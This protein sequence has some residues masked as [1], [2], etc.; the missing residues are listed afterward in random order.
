MVSD[1]GSEDVREFFDRQQ[2]D[3]QYESL[4]NMT[5]ELDV[6]AARL[7]NS[8]V[9][10]DT[11]SIGGIW[12]FFTWEDQMTSLTVLDL[13]P[14]MLKSYCPEHA[15]G[16][17]GDI[18]EQEFPPDSF[19]SIV[20]PLMLHHT[21]K[22][23]WASCEARVEEAIDRARGWLREDGHLFIL[24]YCPQRAWSP[25]QRALLPL[26]KWFLTTF[27][28]PLVVMYEKRFYQ[29]ILNERFGS[30]TIQLVDPPGFN[31]R[32]WYPVFM[33]IRWLRVPMAI[34][35]KLHVISAPALP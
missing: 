25:I 10:G 18:Y 7:L 4:K 15:T 8:K 32:K 16:V 30:C 6:E 5:Q 21:P 9:R 17:V 1:S 3:N 14:E 19:D 2:L 13:S 11:L 26:T 31:Y 24:E 34:Y 28:Q 20:F 22:G 12:D 27:H 33:S 23:N 35:P 29:R